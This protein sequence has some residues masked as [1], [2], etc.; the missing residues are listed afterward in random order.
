MRVKKM[1]RKIFYFIVAVLIIIPNVVVQAEYLEENLDKS[2]KPTVELKNADASGWNQL[3]ENGFGQKTNVAP[4]GMAVYNDE[5][6][7][8]THNAKL[9]KFFSDIFLSNANI[10]FLA[11]MLFFMN[12]K[13]IQTAI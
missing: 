5:L 2:G 6:Y 12:I 9:P 8:G 13:V 1:K 3:T 10:K 7:I 4:R 11:R